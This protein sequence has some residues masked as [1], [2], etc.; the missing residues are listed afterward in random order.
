M[1]SPDRGR[2]L[3]ARYPSTSAPSEEQVLIA[4]ERRRQE[5]ARSACGGLISNAAEAAKSKPAAPEAAMKKEK[6]PVQ[7]SAEELLAD[8]NRLFLT[9]ENDTQR[10]DWL[11]L[12]ALQGS[13]SVLASVVVRECI[14]ESKDKTQPDQWFNKAVLLRLREQDCWSTSVCRLFNRTKRKGRPANAK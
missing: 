3:S 13:Q 7:E 9:D 14:E 8:L 12:V 4:L 1:N 5:L 6:F 11:K 10:K 2:D